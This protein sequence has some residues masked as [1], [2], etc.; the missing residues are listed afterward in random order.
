MHRLDELAQFSAEHN[1]LTRLYLTVELKAAA[2]Q[3]Q[4]WMQAAGMVAHIDAV[5]N[6]VGRYDGRGLGAMQANTMAASGLSRRSRPS[7]RFMKRMS[8]CLSR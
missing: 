5:G 2:L 7:P 8:A 6:V 3:T 4:A 1:A